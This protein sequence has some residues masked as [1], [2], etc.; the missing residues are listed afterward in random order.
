MGARA[1]RKVTFYLSDEVLRAARVSAA[2][3]DKRDSEIVEE[4]LRKHLGFDVLERVWA[5][6]TLG[7]EEAMKLAIAETH[8]H[9]RKRAPR[10]S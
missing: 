2:R 5:R 3:S 4:A 9:R 8:A 1:K 10:R 7:D 6:S